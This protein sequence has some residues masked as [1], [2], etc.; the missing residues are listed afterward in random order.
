M[1]TR[2]RLSAVGGGQEK[3]SPTQQGRACGA[4]EWQNY[5]VFDSHLYRKHCSL[6]GAVLGLQADAFNHVYNKRR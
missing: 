5:A 1:G 3:E 2:R 4:G 6:R